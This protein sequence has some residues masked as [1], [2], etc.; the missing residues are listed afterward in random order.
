MIVTPTTT[1]QLAQLSE[2]HNSGKLTDEEFAASK[3]E[4]LGS[5]DD[6]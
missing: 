6:G 2:L 4:V 3:A 1:D 5:Q